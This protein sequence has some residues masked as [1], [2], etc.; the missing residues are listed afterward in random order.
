MPDINKRWTASGW[1]DVA[2][3]YF[4]ITYRRPGVLG[5][6][7]GSDPL[8]F[9]YPVTLLGFRLGVGTPPAGADLIIDVHKN[10]TTVFTDQANRPRIVAGSSVSISEVTNMDITGLAAGD[11]LTIDVDQV[12]SSTA[13]SALT[14][15]VR[16]TK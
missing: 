4:E 10:G 1:V 6:A 15:F 2:R 14:L 9:P 16:Y 3:T 8:V 7:A 5:V 13:G 11:E 12:G